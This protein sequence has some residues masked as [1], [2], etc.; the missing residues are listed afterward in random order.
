MEKTPIKI[1]A[2]RSEFPEGPAKRSDLVDI[3]FSGGLVRLD[4]GKAKLY[5]GVSDTEA[6]VLTIEDPFLEYENL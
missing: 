5:T 4:G 2:S 6:H 1:I 3:L